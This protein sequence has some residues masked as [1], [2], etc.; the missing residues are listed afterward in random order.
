MRLLIAVFSMVFL[1]FGFVDE[2]YAKR[3]GKGGVGKSHST[4]PYQ[5]PKKQDQNASLAEQSSVNKGSKRTK[6]LGG[7]LGG[8]LAGGLIASML[9]GDF[10]GF[11][12]MDFLL[13][14]MFVFTAFRLF[15]AFKQK[16]SLQYAG[17]EFGMTAPKQAYAGAAGSFRESVT[18]ADKSPHNGRFSST[19]SNLNI[20]PQASASPVQ[21]PMNFTFPAGFNQTLFLND[22]LGH[23]RRLQQGWNEGN[24]ELIA[25]FC[26]PELFES[27]S[28]AHAQL[29]RLPSTEV[30]SLEAEIAMARIEYQVAKLTV[31][32]YGTCYDIGNEIQE[33][34]NDFWH[35]ERDLSSPQAPWV[36]VG[37]EA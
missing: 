7:V 15:R 5:S 20:G 6:M 11:Q 32:F 10:E 37:I 35:L 3:L 25:E 24:M 21:A 23:Y 28:K 30:R 4:I 2:S 22:A 26:A 27:L 16:P 36:V 31:H 14:A 9:G 1:S 13:I 19:Q 33:A 8:L 18:S 17:S 12:W 34:I 29:N